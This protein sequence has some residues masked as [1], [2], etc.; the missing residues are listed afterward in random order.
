MLFDKNFKAEV[1][2]LLPENFDQLDDD[3]KEKAKIAAEE[4]SSL[5]RE[6][7]EM[8]RQWEAGDPEV[9]HL[10]EMMNQW[11]YDG[12]DVTYKRLGVSFDKVYYESQ[13]YLLGKVL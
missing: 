1:K 2:S 6:T 10:W 9:R 3:A 8:L 12:F 5:M 13:T 4:A 11:V 7:R